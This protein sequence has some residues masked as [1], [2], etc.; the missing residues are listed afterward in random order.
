MA[1]LGQT[2]SANEAPAESDY[3]LIPA[4]WYSARITQAELKDTNA[5]TGKYINV[6]YDLTD[7]AHAG[8]VVFGMVTVRNPNA[9]AEE[10]GRQQ[11]GKMCRALGLETVSDTDQLVGGELLIKVTVR[12]S[13]EYGDKNDV[14]D[15]KAQAPAASLPSAPPAPPSAGLPWSK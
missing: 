9:K 7:G 14:K 1:Q 3:S 5:K 10:I 15:W 2:F 8:R 11:I 6:R 4:G 12:R 13:E